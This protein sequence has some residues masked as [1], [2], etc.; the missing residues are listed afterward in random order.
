M[1]MYNDIVY[2]PFNMYICIHIHIHQYMKSM[3]VCMP[4]KINNTFLWSIYIPFD[5]VCSD[6]CIYSLILFDNI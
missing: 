4:I 6:V 3:N 5:C 1:D 2:H